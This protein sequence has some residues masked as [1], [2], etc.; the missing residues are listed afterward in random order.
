VRQKALPA[1][2]NLASSGTRTLFPFRLI[3]HSAKVVR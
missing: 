2:P 3:P 1:R